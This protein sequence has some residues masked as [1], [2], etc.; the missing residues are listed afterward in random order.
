MEVINK[1]RSVRK[2]LD[3]KIENEKIELI[4]KAAMQAPSARNQQPWK[5]LVCQNE[6][7][8]VNLSKTS[9]NMKFVDKA[10]LAI[11]FLTDLDILTV[12]H[13]YSQDMSA[14]IENSLLEA[15]SLG[16]GGCWCGIYP[17]QERMNNLRV[18]FNL[19]QNLEPFAVV[20]YGYPLDEKDLYYLNRY[21]KERVYF[22]KVE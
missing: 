22:E 10:K 4:L 2:Y 13:M 19:P 3:K 8:L 18:L 14:A 20:A 15:C 11:V 16:I 7:T 21:N 6:E 5:F 17:N 12:P 9:P 1:R